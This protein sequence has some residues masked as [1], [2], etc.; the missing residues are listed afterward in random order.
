M[1]TGGKVYAGHFRK[2]ILQDPRFCFPGM[3]LAPLAEDVHRLVLRNVEGDKKLRK[4]ICLQILFRNDAFA[5]EGTLRHRLIFREKHLCSAAVACGPPHLQF[6]RCISHLI[7]LLVAEA[8][9]L[10]DRV[11][12]GRGASAEIANINLLQDIKLDSGTTG[13]AMHV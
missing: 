7:P 5:A 3:V 4:I 9:L 11:S 6:R 1:E 10:R 8:F 2:M 12:R 13:A